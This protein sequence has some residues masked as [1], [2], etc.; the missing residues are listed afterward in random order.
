MP[1]LPLCRAPSKGLFS[2]LE[3]SRRVA[4]K[5]SSETRTR[6]NTSGLLIQKTDA[7]IIPETSDP[8]AHAVVAPVD[9]EIDRAEQ[10]VPA[11]AA[12][13]Q[14]TG[15]LGQ[16]LGEGGLSSGSNVEDMRNWLRGLGARVWRTKGQMWPQLVHAEARQE[17]PKRDE[18]WRA[19]RARGLAEAGGQAELRV[20]RAPEEPSP[21]ERARNEITHLPY[22][23]WCA[24]CVMVK[25][26]AKPYLQRPVESVKVPG[27]EMDFCYLLQ[28]PK[29]RHEPG[30][31][32]RGSPDSVVCRNLDEV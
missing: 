9:E 20:P 16:P 21:E 23:S 1:K 25:G 15:R 29:L 30:D 17:L 8:A 24:W 27:F 7:W 22:Q 18:A 3:S 19:D 11:L 5:S 26:R 31:G 13:W 28:D 4:Q 10:P 2:V 12:D 6:G 32:R 14:G